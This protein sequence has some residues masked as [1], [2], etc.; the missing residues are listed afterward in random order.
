MN[1]TD[2][3][4]LVSVVESLKRAGYDPHDQIYG[5]VTT[6]D[7]CYITR[8]GNARDIIKTIKKEVLRKY[9][10]EK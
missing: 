4:K 2:E 6:N 3:Q 8:Q 5:Y 9:L 1:M 7:E 10:A